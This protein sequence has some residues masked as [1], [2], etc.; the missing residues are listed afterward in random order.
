MAAA[1]RQRR[2]RN[3]VLAVD[4]QDGSVVEYADGVIVI[5]AVWVDIAAGDVVIVVAASGT[6]AA[7]EGGRHFGLR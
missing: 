7:A 3:D 5:R 1:L 4:S 2:K 6:A